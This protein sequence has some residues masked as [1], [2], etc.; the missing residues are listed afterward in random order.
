MKKIIWFF[1]LWIFLGAFI[2]GAYLYIND[3]FSYKKMDVYLT[4]FQ[5]A[6]DF[7][8][9]AQHLTLDQIYVFGNVSYIAVGL[10]ILFALLFKGK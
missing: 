10:I 9:L 6:G 5:N 4:Q 1:L 3:L 2:N 8:T 7:N